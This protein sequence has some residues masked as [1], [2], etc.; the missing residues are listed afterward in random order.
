MPYTPSVLDC[1]Q[2]RNYSQGNPDG[3]RENVDTTDWYP[4]E[5]ELSFIVIISDVAGPGTLDTSWRE[6]SHSRF[7]SRNDGHLQMI[8]SRETNE[9]SPMN[10]DVLRDDVKVSV[11]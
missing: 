2:S 1:I 3:T 7:L 4:F 5:N 11:Q 6:C 9:M 10:L 8:F